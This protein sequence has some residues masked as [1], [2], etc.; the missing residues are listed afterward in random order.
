M[1]SNSSNSSTEEGN[2]ISSSSL[3]KKQISPSKRWCFTLNNF[4]DEEISSIVPIFREYCN[5]AFF[6]KEHLEEGT[7]HLQGYCEFLVKCRPISVFGE[8]CNRICWIKAKG[9][10]QSNLAY[11]TK[12]NPLFFTHGLPEPIKTI[13]KSQFYN[14]QREIHDLIL[15][16][17]DDRTI[18]WYWEDDGNTGKS[19]FTKYLCV[20]HKAIVLSGKASDCFNGILSVM[21]KNGVAPNIV[22][23]D[24]P[25]VC[26]DYISYQAIEKIKDGCFF[27]GKYEGGMCVYNPPHILCF[28]NVPPDAEKLSLDRWN[29]RH[30]CI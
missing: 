28:A 7:P 16:K 13:E 8:V 22:I 11:I 21:D 3:V 18:N 23:F 10:L 4:T 17:P 5:V 9:N 19:S 6:S 30:I 24:I 29:I 1:S 25:R 26:S 15:T 12:E 14:Y 27:S 2:I 20:H